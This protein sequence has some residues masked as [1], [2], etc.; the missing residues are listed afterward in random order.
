MNAFLLSSLFALFFSIGLSFFVFFQNSK[1]VDHQLFSLFLLTLGFWIFGDIFF[2]TPLVDYY[3]PF[4][5]YK[6]SHFGAIVCPSFYFHFIAHF[7]QTRLSPFFIYLSYAVA[8]FFVFCNYVNYEFFK[9]V[10]YLPGDATLNFSVGWVYFMFL[11]FAILSAISGFV[12]AIRRFFKSKGHLKEQMRYFLYGTVF[13]ILAA[14][15]FAFGIAENSSIR[16][17]NLLVVIY[18]SIIAFAL[19]KKQLLEINLIVSRSMA[20]LLSI[21][22]YLSLSATVLL[23][24]RFYVSETVSFALF[25]LVSALL[26]FSGFT[27][28]RLRLR[29]ITT[30]DKIFLKGHYNFRSVL[31]RFVD[32]FSMSTTLEELV[33]VITVRFSADAEFSGVRVYFPQFYE[34]RQQTDDVFVNTKLSSDTITLSQFSPLQSIGIPLTSRD[35]SPD[36]QAVL[37]Y[38]NAHAI[39]P[40]FSQTEGLICLILLGKK[41]SED[42]INSDD[43]DLFNAIRMQIP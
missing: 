25:A 11:A 21:A 3:S 32:G 41:L 16:L 20:N 35:T 27:F 23:L 42:A 30:A 40:C 14:S 24:Y 39:I 9:T 38:L 5:W 43:I 13:I 28:E 31:Q 4:F 17:D 2:L 36:V 10:T 19:T 22:I 12:F 15:T 37:N 34:I 18:V 7:T 29:I 6:L 8:A 26:L 1:S 33:K